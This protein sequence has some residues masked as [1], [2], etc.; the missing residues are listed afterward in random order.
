MFGKM[1]L[2]IGLLGGCIWCLALVA[3]A[4]SA[5]SVSTTVPFR[6]VA[7]VDALM[8]GQKAFFKGIKKA[9]AN[10]TTEH[11]HHKIEQAAEVLAELAN[12]NRL[13]NAKEDYRAW[14]TQLRNV[15]LTL[16]HKAKEKD[17]DEAEMMELYN[18]L[19][20]TCKACHDVYQD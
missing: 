19:R 1:T 15:A 9:L 8:H 11:R 20:A 18:Q 17:A 13:N 3:R 4:D 16:A 5:Q 12:V 6:P 10:K 7:S 2:T 14:A